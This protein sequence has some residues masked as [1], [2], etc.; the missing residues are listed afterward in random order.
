MASSKDLNLKY[1]AMLKNKVSDV[2]EGSQMKNSEKGETADALRKAQQKEDVLAGNVKVGYL[3]HTELREELTEDELNTTIANLE[4]LE[5]SLEEGVK[6]FPQNSI[7]C[8]LSSD[9]YLT[10]EKGWEFEVTER[11]ILIVESWHPGKLDEL[12]ELALEHGLGLLVVL[13]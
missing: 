11:T 3:N 6:V 12:I 9:V 1:E 4:F 8:L 7:Y 10:K 13:I 2:L 5:V